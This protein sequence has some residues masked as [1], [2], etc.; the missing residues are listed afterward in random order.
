MGREARSTAKLRAE[1]RVCPTCGLGEAPLTEMV[2]LCRMLEAS[3]GRIVLA[4][5]LQFP[6]TAECNFLFDTIGG[7]RSL[8]E[9]E[10]ER[11][12]ARTEGTTTHAH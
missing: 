12:R 4:G 1:Q 2:A 6:Q 7:L 10:A 9:A 11:E 5:G 3:V 8:F